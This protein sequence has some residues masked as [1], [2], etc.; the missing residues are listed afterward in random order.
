[1]ALVYLYHEL[2]W[3][4]DLALSSNEIEI[5]LLM[6]KMIQDLCPISN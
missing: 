1:M 3:L 6:N 2:T 4:S 5:K